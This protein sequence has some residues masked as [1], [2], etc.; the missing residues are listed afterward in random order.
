MKRVLI[1]IGYL[2]GALGDR[3]TIG[4]TYSAYDPL[5]KTLWKTFND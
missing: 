1:W 4:K 2:L 5:R 3:T